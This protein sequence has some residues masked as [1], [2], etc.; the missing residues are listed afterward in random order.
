MDEKF[1]AYQFDISYRRIIHRGSC[2]FCRDGQGTRKLGNKPAKNPS[3]T[4]GWTELEGVTEDTVA[5]YA[6]RE[7]GR[8]CK[9]CFD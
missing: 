1:Y 2:A 7:D 3:L 4:S 8:L 6:L 5:E 9:Q